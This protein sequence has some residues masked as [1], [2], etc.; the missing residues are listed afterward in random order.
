MQLFRGEVYYLQMFQSNFLEYYAKNS[1][2]LQK[3]SVL[4]NFLSKI[5]IDIFKILEIWF[6]FPSQISIYLKEN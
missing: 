2:Q 1:V 5:C 3:P 6:S 4:F